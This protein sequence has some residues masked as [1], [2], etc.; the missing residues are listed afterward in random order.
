MEDGN[1]GRL[2]ILRLGSEVQQVSRDSSLEPGLLQELGGER[3]LGGR[4][5]DILG[6]RRPRLEQL[7]LDRADAAAYLEHRA[8]LD[9][10]PADEVDNAARAAVD[11]RA[12]VVSGIPTG[13]PLDEELVAA[14]WR[15][16][17]VS[18]DVRGG[19][20]VE[21]RDDGGVVGAGLAATGVGVVLD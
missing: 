10:V 20:E 21:G 19:L 11:T 1:V 8:P 14:L 16:G 18:C 5:L 6:A 13:D 3:L 17:P 4:E 12:P 15:T 9:A 2:D 7:Q